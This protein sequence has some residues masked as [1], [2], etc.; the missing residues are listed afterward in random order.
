MYIQ[1]IGKMLALPQ[2]A[3][4][5]APTDWDILPLGKGGCMLLPPLARGVGG[6]KI[7]ILHQ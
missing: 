1:E 3:A 4:E 7:L 2:G 6:G 5:T